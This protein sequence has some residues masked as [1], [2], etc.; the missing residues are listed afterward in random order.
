MHA[1]Q[2]ARDQTALADRLASSDLTALKIGPQWV[3]ET[4]DSV[5]W[6]PGLL[7]LEQIDLSKILHQLE[8]LLIDPLANVWSGWTRVVDLIKTSPELAYPALRVLRRHPLFRT[9]GYVNPLC[10]SLVVKDLNANSKHW[11]APRDEESAETF[12]ELL[13]SFTNF[14]LPATFLALEMSTCLKPRGKL[15]IEILQKTA[16]IILDESSDYELVRCVLDF[17]SC[18]IRET[19][20]GEQMTSLLGDISWLFKKKLDLDYP[21]ISPMAALIGARYIG[22]GAA[23]WSSTT[24]LGVPWLMS[25]LTFL[26]NPKHSVYDKISVCRLITASAANSPETGQLYAE[27]NG[28]GIAIQLI[29][30]LLDSK[31]PAEWCLVRSLLHMVAEL[32]DGTEQLFPLIARLLKCKSPSTVTVT[33]SVLTRLIQHD[34]GC[35]PQV[36]AADLVSMLPQSRESAE[37]VAQCLA[38]VCVHSEG[39]KE[40]LRVGNPICTQVLPLFATPTSCEG[41]EGIG[42]ACEELIRNKPD[43]WRIKIVNSLNLIFQNLAQGSGGSDKIAI[44]QVLQSACKLVEVICQKN[45]TETISQILKTEIPKNIFKITRFFCPP[46]FA[47]VVPSHSVC[48]LFKV[49]CHHSFQTHAKELARGIESEAVAHDWPLHAANAVVETVDR[50][51]TGQLFIS[52]MSIE[53]LLA[54]LAPIQF[55]LQVVA[56][57]MKDVP[58]TTNGRVVHHL[59][60]ILTA[61]QVEIDIG[62]FPNFVVPLAGSNRASISLFELVALCACSGDPIDKADEEKELRRRIREDRPWPEALFNC[63][64]T[65]TELV[66][67]LWLVVRGFMCQAA[68]VINYPTVPKQQAR[69][70]QTVAVSV[71]ARGASQILSKLAISMLRLAL[72]GGTLLSESV[73]LLCRL[74]VEDKHHMTRSLCVDT[75]YKLGGVNDVLAIVDLCTTTDMGHAD[76]DETRG[77]PL[78]SIL[79]WFERTTSLKRMHNAQITHL[80]QGGDFDAIAL[81]SSLQAEFARGFATHWRNDECIQKIISAKAS[82]SLLKAFTHVLEPNELVLRSQ[83]PEVA[84]TGGLIASLIRRATASLS[85]GED[86]PSIW[87]HENAGESSNIMSSLFRSLDRVPYVPFPVVLDRAKDIAKDFME[88]TL[89]LGA[90]PQTAAAAAQ[91]HIADVCVRLS[92]NKILQLGS[93]SEEVVQSILAHVVDNEDEHVGRRA[94]AGT[95]VVVEDPGDDTQARIDAVMMTSEESQSVE[96]I[97]ET[98]MEPVQVLTDYSVFNTRH[99]AETCLESNSKIGFTILACLLHARFSLCSDIVSVFPSKVLSEW[100]YDSALP[101]WTTSAFICIEKLLAITTIDYTRM[102]ALCISGLGQGPAPDE[103]EALFRVALACQSNA[104]EMREREQMALSGLNVVLKLE[105]FEGVQAMMKKLISRPPIESELFRLESEIVSKLKKVGTRGMTLSQ[106]NRIMG[107]SV[108]AKYIKLSTVLDGL[109][110][111]RSRPDKRPRLDESDSP[112]LVTLLPDE[113]RLRELRCEPKSG[114][115]EFDEKII[116]V[117]LESLTS[118]SAFNILFLIESVCL[119]GSR[120]SQAQGDCMLVG[121]L[122]EAHFSLEKAVSEFEQDSKKI[123]AVQQSLKLIETLFIIAK[124]YSGASVLKVVE[125]FVDAHDPSL[126]AVLI[127]RALAIAGSGDDWVKTWCATR[128][129]EKAIGILECLELATRPPVTSTIPEDAPA[130]LE[131]RILALQITAQQPVEEELLGEAPGDAEDSSRA[132]RPLLLTEGLELT[133]Q[134]LSPMVSSGTARQLPQ[135]YARSSPGRMIDDFMQTQTS[136]VLFSH[137]R[138]GVLWSFPGEIPADHPFISRSHTGATGSPVLAAMGSHDGDEQEMTE[139]LRQFAPRD[140]HLDEIQ[141]EVGD[142]DMLDG[143]MESMA[144]FERRLAEMEQ[145]AEAEEEEARRAEDMY[146]LHEQLGQHPDEDLEDDQDAGNRAN[147]RAEWTSELLRLTEVATEQTVPPPVEATGPAE[148]TAQ[149]AEPMDQAPVEPSIAGPPALHRAASRFG[150]SVLDFVNLTGIDPG[151]L[152]D[153]PEEMHGQIIAEYVSQL[154]PEVLSQL[155]GSSQ[156]A[157]PE[158]DNATFLSTITQPEIRQ[159]IFLTASEEFLAS[160]PP[161]L[162]AEAIMARERMSRAARRGRLARPSLVDVPRHQPSANAMRSITELFNRALV[163]RPF[164]TTMVNVTAPAEEVADLMRMLGTRLRDYS[165]GLFVS[166]RLQQHYRRKRLRNCAITM[167]SKSIRARPCFFLKDCWKL[168]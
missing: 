53:T 56:M 31:T 99:I 139:W 78:Q 40:V 82:A 84:S 157:A 11:L 50:I 86:R 32:S 152:G 158:P 57:A 54:Q 55:A 148:P 7:R 16:S 18:V 88:R 120:L 105:H 130:V 151:V 117:L 100:N 19:S 127:H 61:L 5:M 65:R 102:F 106:L 35:I 1:D 144:E 109:V 34:P 142:E 49:F 26:E 159:E 74:H 145:F 36:I 41:A 3:W 98:V 21:L 133:P 62:R 2:I 141:V 46:N 64:Q 125:E 165:L 81:V 43:P 45:S 128:L 76:M 69:R 14:A 68:R 37:S 60:T 27:H 42:A 44:V 126:A 150:I 20:S 115:T 156:N 85:L 59:S 140:S 129:E 71:A 103:A 143:D 112:V 138:P 114:L 66:R 149:T 83:E 97:E 22:I 77:T 119:A 124:T 108:C 72:A 87:A 70:L 101:D 28:L 135:W 96:T 153:L 134:L 118:K 90:S 24:P 154:D 166:Q 164:G 111:W 6:M 38:A 95:V 67:G 8:V 13:S 15:S 161:D 121:V 73:D 131:E 33:V 113:L 52:V 9:P 104:T 137:V 25:G 17:A 79:W 107:T 163:D 160:L 147:E 155:G 123:T 4:T 91:T 122:P 51:Q 47:H 136:S 89:V 12:L 92:H 30:D 116:S 63:K 29:T 168:C 167:M 110:A 94:R 23:V 10:V 75:F 132:I 80:L 93:A 162:H 48:K 146:L 39:E 58:P